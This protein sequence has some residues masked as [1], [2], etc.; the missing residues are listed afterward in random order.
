MTKFSSE[1]EAEL[2]K[3]ITYFNSTPGLKISNEALGMKCLIH[4]H[5]NTYK[6][7]KGKWRMLIFDGHGSHI[8]EPF[9]LYCWQHKIVPFQ[10]PPHSTHLLQPL[11]IGIFQPLKHWHQADILNTIQYGQIEYSKIDFLNGYAAIRYKTFR[12]LTVN[13]L[14]TSLLISIDVV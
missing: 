5:N 10:L 1:R 6:K 7:V 4:F 3:A 11:D 13:C 8:S 2:A 14:M 9:L 12:I